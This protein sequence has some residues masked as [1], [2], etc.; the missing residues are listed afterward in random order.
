MATEAEILAKLNAK[1]QAKKD[2]DAEKIAILLEVEDGQ[3]EITKEQ[4]EQIAT[5]TPTAL[6]ENMFFSDETN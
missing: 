5:L 2:E 1:N 4:Y 6:F 3:M